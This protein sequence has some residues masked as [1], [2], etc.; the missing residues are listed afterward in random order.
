MSRIRSRCLTG[1]R[2]GTCPNAIITPHCA[3]TQATSAEALCRFVT[4]NVRR[5]G[6]GEA[7]LGAVNVDEGY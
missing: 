6:H 5:F 4:E 7:L 3:T 2:S 1:I